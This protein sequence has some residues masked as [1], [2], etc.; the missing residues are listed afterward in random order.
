MAGNHDITDAKSGYEN[1]I[2][3]LKRSTIAVAVVTV[4]VVLIIASRA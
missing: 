2:K 3:N 1:F 4:I